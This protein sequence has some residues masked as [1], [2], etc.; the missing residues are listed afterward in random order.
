MTRTQVFAVLTLVFCL[1]LGIVPGSRALPAGAS[2]PSSPVKVWS[3]VPSQVLL[4]LSSR[5]NDEGHWHPFTSPGPMRISWSTQRGILTP[6]DRTEPYFHIAI[7]DENNYTLYDLTAGEPSGGSSTILRSCPHDCSFYVSNYGLA[8]NLTVALV[9]DARFVSLSTR[10]NISGES[11]TFTSSG[12][13]TIRW[14]AQRGVRDPG[15]PAEPYCFIHIYDS[16]ADLYSAS[17]WD[18]PA[19]GSYVV[20]R[21]CHHVCRADMMAYGLTYKVT[22]SQ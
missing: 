18:N 13:F 8:Y 7:D 11:A 22:V 17:T 1:A 12:P 19:S 16:N 20:R 3:G 5:A 2:A 9:P 10:G 21:S 4:S 14:I 15:S 6:H